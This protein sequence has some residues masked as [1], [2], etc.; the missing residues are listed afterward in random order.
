MNR[1]LLCPT[2]RAT[3]FGIT[4]WGIGC[5]RAKFPGVYVKVSKY[6]LW[7]RDRLELSMENRTIHS[8]YPDELNLGMSNI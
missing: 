4:S 7:I 5:G 3:L 8:S 2:E 6:I 1:E